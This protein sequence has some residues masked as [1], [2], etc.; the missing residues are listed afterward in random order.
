MQG[1]HSIRAESLAMP[2]ASSASFETQ[3]VHLSEFLLLTHCLL[4]TFKTI[5]YRYYVSKKLTRLACMIYQISVKYLLGTH[6]SYY[7]NKAENLN[8][9]RMVWSL[10][11]ENMRQE[12]E[13]VTFSEQGSGNT[14]EEIVTSFDNMNEKC[15][16]ITIS[17]LITKISVRKFKTN[18][19]YPRF[20]IRKK[21]KH[22][23]HLLC[24]LKY[25]IICRKINVYSQIK[26]HSFIL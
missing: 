8:L 22:T 25:D 6:I 11:R 13:A 3:R 20:I 26:Y 10:L 18:F 16:F 1:Y 24:R 12:A 2:V 4:Y 15:F 5:C 7:H 9:L 23:Y 17:G 21:C 14:A 19:F